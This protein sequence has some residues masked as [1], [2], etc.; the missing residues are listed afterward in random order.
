[1]EGAVRMGK[2]LGVHSVLLGSF[3]IFEDEMWLGARLVKVETSEILLTDEIKGDV[4]EFYDLTDKLCYNIAEKIDVTLGSQESSLS[5]ETRSLD[6]LLL[7]SEGLTYIE[8]QDYQKAYDKFLKA[9]KYDPDY[10]NAKTKAESIK[11]LLG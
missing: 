3:I 6:A 8:K 1:M 4:A 10:I 7:Y 9:L 2:Q 5:T 11:P